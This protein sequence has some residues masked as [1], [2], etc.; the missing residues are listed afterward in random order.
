LFGDLFTVSSSAAAFTA[1]H[2]GIQ[3]I[4]FCR[5]EL[6]ELDSYMAS[7]ECRCTAA[8]SEQVAKEVVINL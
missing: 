1:G 6:D 7:S 4:Q 5:A 2:V 3:L 8:D